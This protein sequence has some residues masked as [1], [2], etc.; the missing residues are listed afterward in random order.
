MGKLD[1]VLDFMQAR[2]VGNT[3]LMLNG[4]AYNQPA[5]MIFATELHASMIFNDIAD[6]APRGVKVNRAERKVG[7]V[8][9]VSLA[10]FNNEHWRKGRQVAVAIDHF[11]LTELI[12]EDRLEW[13]QK[14]ERAA[15]HV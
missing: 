5:I 1:L 4:L 10:D 8:Q 13:Q 2:G 15:A 12:K 9:F 3:E 6:G 7:E 11:A 14:V